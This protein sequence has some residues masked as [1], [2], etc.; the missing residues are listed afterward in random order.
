MN[1]EQL[2]GICRQF[3][4]KIRQIRGV[5]TGDPIEESIG[6]REQVSGKSQQDN[7]IACEQADRQLK[8]FHEQ[9]RNWYF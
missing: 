3:V 1:K 5:W 8:E 4:G 7:G 2:T 9:H 6:R